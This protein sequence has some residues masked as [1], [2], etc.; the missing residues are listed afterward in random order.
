MKK[1]TLGFS[2][3]QASECSNDKSN[4]M[5]QLSSDKEDGNTGAFQMLEETY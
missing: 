5:H 2:R 1:A 4:I 3:R